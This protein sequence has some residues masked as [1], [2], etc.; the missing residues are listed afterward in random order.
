MQTIQDNSRLSFFPEI[1]PFKTGFL[2]VTECHRLYYEEAGNPEG[3][4][5]IVVH[6]GPGGGINPKQRRY[7]DPDHYRIISLDQRGA[8]Q[9]LPY[10]ELSENTTWDL[11]DD[12]E[13]LRE[14]CQV[15]QWQVFG[16]SWGTTLALAYAIS[17]SER[18]SSLILRGIF[19]GRPRD[20]HWLYQEGASNIF[21]E[22]H[23]V[24][25]EHIPPAEQHNLI[26]A[27]YQR[28]TSEHEGIRVP[29]AQIW[30]IWEA[31]ISKLIPDAAIIEAFEN[32]DFAVA[33]ARIECHYFVHN[34]FFKTHNYLLE[35]AHH[36]HKIPGKI[37]HGRYDIVCAAENAWSLHQ[38]WPQAQLVMVPDAGHSGSEPGT[39][40][41]LIEAT[42]AFKIK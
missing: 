42:E 20:I 11:V 32:P 38:A 21:P 16:G 33:F 39:L 40:A 12:M 17:H 5:V 23:Q 37:V 26:E 13:F 36:L 1:E 41:A 10:A 29:A 30:S 14:H 18:V 25:R 28:L 2:Q 9:S 6:G 31:A 8:G 24:F 35:Q 34:C 4:A 19:L 22:A 3:Q 27:Y 15:S 7:F